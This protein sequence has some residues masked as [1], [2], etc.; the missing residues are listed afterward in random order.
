VKTAGHVT[1][2]AAVGKQIG[3]INSLYIKWYD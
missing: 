3:M 2:W 1:W